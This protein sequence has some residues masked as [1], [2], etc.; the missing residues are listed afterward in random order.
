MNPPKDL[1]NAKREVKMH[2]T[3]LWAAATLLAVTL[4]CAGFQLP[5]RRE[6]ELKVGDAAPDFTIK[7]V[8]GKK[9]VSLSDLK[10]KPLVLVFGSCT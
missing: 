2:S 6:G 5:Q 10:G 3:R 4:A 9:T 8:E 1:S 7:D